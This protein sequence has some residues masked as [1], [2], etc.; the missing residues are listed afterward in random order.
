M[1]TQDDKE[2]KMEIKENSNEAMLLLM[3]CAMDMD[4]KV[5]YEEL[6]LYNKLAE[7][8]ELNK[9]VT[10]ELVLMSNT[11]SVGYCKKAKDAITDPVLR[12]STFSTMSSIALID[13][14]FH[15]YERALL[16]SLQKSWD[17]P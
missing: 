16:D 3:L 4:D 8:L 1:P 9:D 11:D 7:K 17:L 5:R 2:K 14:E 10:E 12:R 6:V 15:P 13:K